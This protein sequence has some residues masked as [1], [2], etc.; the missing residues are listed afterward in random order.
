[1]TA[2]ERMR[3]RAESNG[4]EV[5]AGTLRR[6]LIITAPDTARMW[7]R[8]DN[9]GRL[10]E[11]QIDE[12]Q[13]SSVMPAANLESRVVVWIGMH[14]A[15][16]RECGLGMDS[17]RRGVVTDGGRPCPRTGCGYTLPCPDHAADSLTLDGPF[18]GA[19]FEIGINGKRGLT[20]TRGQLARLV[21]L[22]SDH[23]IIA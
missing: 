14:Q 12:R 19:T 18:G 4:L 13:R 5:R 9:A 17:T 16:Q 7:L 22:A 15:V 3:D 6:E 1:M 11:A 21:R 23:G 8:Y 20:I 2:I 10:I